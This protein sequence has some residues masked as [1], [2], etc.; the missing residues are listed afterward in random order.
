M[1]SSDSLLRSLSAAG[2]KWYQDCNLTPWTVAGSTI[3][4]WDPI[5]FGI[6]G[7][8]LLLV[9]ETQQTGFQIIRKCGKQASTDNAHDV[10][11]N[12]IIVCVS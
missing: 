9:N 4:H 10:I 6:P 2:T 5:Y 7:R 12:T 3:D 11:E 8:E 1:F